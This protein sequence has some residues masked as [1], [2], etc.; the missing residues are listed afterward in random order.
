MPKLL[1]KHF[2]I[3]KSVEYEK[4]KIEEVKGLFDKIICDFDKE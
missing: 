4:E 1:K 3:D 2:D